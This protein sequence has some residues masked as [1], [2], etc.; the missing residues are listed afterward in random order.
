MWILA[1]LFLAKEL[2]PLDDYIDDPSN[3]PIINGHAIF[4]LVS[5]FPLLIPR[6][7]SWPFSLIPPWKVIRALVVVVAPLTAIAFLFEFLSPLFLSLDKFF[8]CPWW[9]SF[10]IFSLRWM[11]SSISWP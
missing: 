5:S 8:K 7:V 2:G 9:M 3:E 1:C 4:L 6:I 11:N 10:S